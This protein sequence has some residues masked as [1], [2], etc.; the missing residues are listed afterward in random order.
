MSIS[1]VQHQLN[2]ASYLNQQATVSVFLGVKEIQIDQVQQLVTNTYKLTF[3]NS[4]KKIILHTKSNNP[5]V[6]GNQL[7]KDY[8]I[9]QKLS[10]A[11]MPVPKTLFYCGDQS[12]VGVPFYATEYV[13]GRLFNDKKLLSVSQTEK[14]L[15][16]QE[17]S[18]ALAHLHSISL[19]YLGLGELESQTS[20]YQTQNKKLYNLYKLHETKISTNVEDLLY[21]LPLNTPVKSELDNLCL[22][23]GDFSLSKVVF[24]PTEPKVLA[25]LDWQ[26]AQL[27]NAFIDL[28][29]FVSPYYIPYSNGQHQVDG[30][31]GIEEIIGQPNLQ[32]VLQAYFTTRSSE[33]IPDIK[34][35]L[36]MSILKQ[37]IDQQILYKQTKEEKY[38]DNS[39]FLSKA[40]YEIILR[41]TEGDPFGIKMRAT[42]DGQLWS[43]WP[44]SER[45]KSYYYRIKDFMRDEIFP[46]EKTILDK[47]RAIPT[48]VQNKPILE[49]EE[50]QRKAR[51]AGLWNLFISDP[52]Y[53]KG[54]TNLEYVFLSE[55]MGLSYLAHETFN[56]FAPETGNIKLLIAYGTPYQKEKYLKPL[57]EGQCKSFFA[58]T[59]KN[60]PSSDPNNF[61]CTITP[62]EGGFI[63]NGGKWFVSS[64]PDER[65]IFGIVMGKSSPDMS[66]PIESQS[67][68]LVDMNNP[69]IKIIRQ[70]PVL[71]F[72]DIPHGYSEVEFDNAFIPQ[73]NL[74][75]QLGGAFKMAQ[76]RLLGGRL[77]HCVRQVGLTRRCLDLMMSRSEKRIIFKQS[78][79]DNA[80]FQER[81]GDLEIAFQSCR[82]LSLN[83]GLL[84]DSAGSRH[85][86][87]FMAVSEC[88]AHIP[89]ACQ[90]II[91]Q[92][93]QAFGAEGV[94]EEQPLALAFRFAR[95]I[96]FMDGPCEVHLRQISRFAYG[97]HLFN[98]LNNAQGYGLAKL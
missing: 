24:H 3:K 25:I 68:I 33:N 32:D 78:L 43:N 31:F 89:K 88:K 4:N 39:H 92:C 35:Q 81:L 60:V 84:L 10:A 67:M 41:M 8:L 76:G 87:T 80:A 5:Q 59:E 86:H 97:N 64:A 27:G 58:M 52:M 12:I 63:L 44:V 42:N 56:C 20:Q 26:Q 72:Y 1:E 13:E 37:S 45:C 83:A 51:A 75:G 7:E 93:V 74:L 36:I 30:W 71:G 98:D 40:G 53:G 96:R 23:H 29:S 21:W 17:V 38:Q 66:N 70:F 16:F 15:L 18:K 48:T 79:K 47:A 69:K 65:A 91:D 9:A 50:L 6:I 61:Q 14:K 54:L 57:L 77:H 46:V 82:L 62:T 19:N 49:V 90:Y 2:L 22:V 55:L 34:Y 95:A 73:E 85:L 11:N 94:T 28:A